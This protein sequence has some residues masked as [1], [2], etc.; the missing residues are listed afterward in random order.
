MIEYLELFYVFFLIGLFTFGGGYAMI[1]LIQSEV[2]ERGWITLTE[3]HDLLVISESTPGPI[4]IN[5]ATFVGNLRFGIP[6]AL[7]AT[8]AVVLPSFIIILLIAMIFKRFQ[9]NKVINAILTGIKAVVIGLIL[10]TALTFLFNIIVIDI[11]SYEFDYVALIILIFIVSVSLIFK[12]VK[13]KS[14]SPYLILIMC[15][16]FG[17]LLYTIQSII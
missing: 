9:D 6:G 11:S 8:F 4:A 5:A 3:F 15:G 2:V 1:S 13:Q 7:V 12:K 10:S 14:L 17:I 16:L